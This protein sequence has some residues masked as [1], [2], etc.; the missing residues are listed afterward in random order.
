MS[1]GRW[2]LLYDKNHGGVAGLGMIVITMYWSVGVEG[3]YI[4][5]PIFDC[6]VM[7]YIDY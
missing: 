5:Q 1:L 6:A 2:G 4:H 7:D 3:E